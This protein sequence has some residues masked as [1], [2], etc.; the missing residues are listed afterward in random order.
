[1]L[2]HLQCGKK[3]RMIVESNN[4]KGVA[5]MT[6]SSDKMQTY[7]LT[8]EQTIRLAAIGVKVSYFRHEGEIIE[9]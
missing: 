5:E 7:C 6:V 3:D 9:A 8:D 2:D 4:G 1:M